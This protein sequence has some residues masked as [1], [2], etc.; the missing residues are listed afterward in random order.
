MARFSLLPPSPSFVMH[1]SGGDGF[2]ADGKRRWDEKPK[3]WAVGLQERGRKTEMLFMAY[4][5]DRYGKLPRRMGQ[6]MATGAK[7]KKDGTC[8]PSQGAESMRRFQDGTKGYY[9]ELNAAGSR[10]RN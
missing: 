9:A 1:S 3:R 10:H 7:T 5:I 2:Q 4:Q 6:L 8:P